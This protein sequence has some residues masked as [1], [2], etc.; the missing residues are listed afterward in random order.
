MKQCFNQ[1]QPL[2]INKHIQHNETSLI[3]LLNTETK[4]NIKVV[5]SEGTWKL[6]V[7]AA[8]GLGGFQ[9]GDSFNLT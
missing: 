2:P 5:I 3:S 1:N 7:V 9:N 4:R 6:D 8:R